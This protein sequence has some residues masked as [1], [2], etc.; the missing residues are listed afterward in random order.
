MGVAEGA[1]DPGGRTKGEGGR[2]MLNNNVK[3]LFYS[4][5]LTLER[6][7]SLFHRE[8]LRSVVN[9]EYLISLADEHLT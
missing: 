6:V 8:V 2:H 4:P 1:C 7:W 3:L 9:S 5:V